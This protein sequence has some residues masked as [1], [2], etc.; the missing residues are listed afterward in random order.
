MRE[1]RVASLRY[2]GMLHDV[3][4]LGV[5]TTVLQKAGRLTEAEFDAQLIQKVFKYGSTQKIMFAGDKVVTNLMAIAKNKWQPI[6]IDGGY[7]IKFTRYT[8]FAGDLLV[9]LHPQFRQIP[10]MESTAVLIDFPFLK[11]RFLQGRD[12]QLLKDRQSPAM[13][14][15]LHEY[16]TE[17]GLELLQDKVHTVIRNWTKLA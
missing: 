8:T 7:G 14:G 13:D 16:L 1:D 6:T 5:P 3:G 15:V 4:K 17:C 2:A 11:Y 12:T 9:H 10:G